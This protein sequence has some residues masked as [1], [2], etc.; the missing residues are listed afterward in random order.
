MSA[1]P[2]ITPLVRPVR[3]ALA[4]ALLAACWSAHAQLEPAQVANEPGASVSGAPI[5]LRQTPSTVRAEQRDALPGEGLSTMPRR[6]LAERLEPPQPY[7]PDDFERYVRKLAGIDESRAVATA[8]TPADP[9]QPDIRRFGV[10][11]MTGQAMAAADHSALVPADYIVAAGDE[12]MVTLWGS[13]DADVRATVDRSGRISLPRVGSIMVA[14]TR[15]AD[16]PD[17]IG[18]RVGQV[19]KNFQISVGLGQL[20][21]VRVYVT[22]FAKQPGAHFVASLSTIVNVLMR[23]GGPSAAGSFRHIELRRAGKTVSSFDLYDLLL[24][25]DKAADAI[26]QAEDVLYIGPVGAQIGAIGS[27]NKPAVFE[28]KAGETVGDV[29]VMAGGFTA[30]A[31]R[32]RLSVERLSERGEKRIAQLRMP[33]ASKDM[34]ASG[35]VLRSFSEVDARLSTQLQNKRVRIEGEV[36]KPGEYILT[37]DSTLADALRTAGGLTPLAY[38]FGA[39]FTRESVRVAQQENYE[40]ALRDLEVEFAKA[41]Y[42]RRAISADEAAAQAAAGSGSSVLI[43]R[44]R[45][46]RPNGRVVLQL[47]PA[48]PEI[49][50]LVVEDGDRLYIPPRPNTVGVF[51]SVFNGGNYLFAQGRT[52][53]DFLKLAGGATRGADADSTFVLRANGS[54]VSARQRATWISG[55]SLAGVNAQPGDTIFVP[56]EVGKT[57]FVQA[58][59]EWTQILAQFG[60]GVAAINS[61]K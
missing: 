58:A 3:M 26:V 45:D 39:E 31:D 2:W 9:T 51:G 57:T 28:L 40:R 7:K 41:A 4:A 8:T 16:L 46:V 56:E 25:G 29:I 17:V 61:L 44:L 36:A 6:P 43:Q 52:V 50:P 13:V 33:D 32:T 15:Y 35:D 5:R 47:D 53:D 49:P 19:F 37:P 20:R 14:G 48:A 24:K 54:V 21:S 27:F 55:G 18:R 10:D 11:L 22:G 30:V 42:T 34:L 60:L 23:S 59:K 12:L 38:V 1:D